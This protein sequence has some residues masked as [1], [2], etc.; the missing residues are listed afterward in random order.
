MVGKGLHT[1]IVVLL[2]VDRV[3]ID[4]VDSSLLHHPGIRFALFSV[5]QRV[6]VPGRR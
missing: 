4:G 5:Q 6:Q 2:V 3:N 1:A